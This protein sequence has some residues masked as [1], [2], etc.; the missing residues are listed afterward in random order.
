MTF[1]VIGT[2]SSGNCYLLCGRHETL[3]VEAGVKFIEVK[4]ALN[5][6]LSN[7]VGCVCSH[8]HL[9]HAKYA[10]EFKNSGIPVLGCE[11][12]N[13]SK[14][15][16]SG[17][18]YNVGGFRIMPLPVYHDC[19]CFAYII[20]HDE[21]G[22]LVFIT[23]TMTFN[24]DIPGVNHL[25]IEA[26]YDDDILNHNV[27]TGLLDPSLRNRVVQ[28]HLSLDTAIDTAKN[29]LNPH[30]YNLIYVHLSG[31]NSDVDTF[32]TKTRRQLGMT[33]IIAKKGL[34]VDL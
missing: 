19:P 2:G 32:I 14:V 34:C 22:K 17:K 33:P 18:G 9:D 4:K 11:N 25:V 15:V 10:S 8:E 24:Y 16:E 28:S 1:K 26:N 20:S 21:M 5:F 13:P 29:L 12:I 30:L 7:I 23:D 3:I 27:E 6:D 31:G